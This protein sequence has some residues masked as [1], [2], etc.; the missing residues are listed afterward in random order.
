ME[1]KTHMKLPAKET[2]LRIEDSAWNPQAR[3]FLFSIKDTPRFQIEDQKWTLCFCSVAKLLN[4]FRFLLP[5]GSASWAQGWARCILSPALITQHCCPVLKMCMYFQVTFLS[6]W[7]YSWV[8]CDVSRI[9]HSAE[10]QWAATK[11]QHPSAWLLVLLVSD[12][13]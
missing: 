4:Y 8:S 2:L 12:R 5:S 11:A 13:A 7:S 9:C 6:A 1:E 3:F 10:G